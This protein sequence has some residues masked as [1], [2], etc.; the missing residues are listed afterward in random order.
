MGDDP[1][2]HRDEMEAAV[3]VVHAEDDVEM[4]SGGVQSVS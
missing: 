4:P 1:T 3:E 2:E